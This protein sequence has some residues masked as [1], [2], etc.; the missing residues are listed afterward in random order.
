M[1]AKILSTI[2]FLVVLVLVSH[3]AWIVG[4]VSHRVEQ[5]ADGQTMASPPSCY[6]FPLLE[7]FA[8]AHEHVNASLGWA[9]SGVWSDEGVILAEWAF[10]RLVHI[11]ISYGEELVVRPIAEEGI[12]RHVNS[13]SNS[14]RN[15]G[16]PYFIHRRERTGYLLLVRSSYEAFRSVFLLNKERE[17]EQ[18]ILTR[19]HQLTDLTTGD[20]VVLRDVF[21]LVPI[22]SGLLLYGTVEASFSEQWFGYIDPSE[23][24][25]R[26]FWRATAEHHEYYGMPDHHYMAAT[27]DAAFFLLATEW[28]RIARVDLPSLEMR[29]LDHF[30]LDFKVP[31]VDPGSDRDRQVDILYD[32]YEVYLAARMAVGLIAW[33][34][35]VFIVGKGAAEISG[36]DSGN[37]W[38][39]IRISP[40]TGEEV[41]RILLPTKAPHIVLVPGPKFLTIIE[42][43]RIDMVGDYRNATL[44]R[45]TLSGVLLPRADWLDREVTAGA[46][47]CSDL[48]ITGAIY[49]Q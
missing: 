27:A 40:E 47:T 15:I 45:S 34:E 11:P 39:L 3:V 31:K 48:K 1:K 16:D 46:V 5:V 19:D 9:N 44:G 22:G 21:Q 41:S 26:R 38:W 33:D 12:L 37:D 43:G 25:Y 18:E 36:N 7:Y 14:F 35:K 24:T 8:L 2:A 23:S 32:K 13:D 4:S 17:I 10:Q 29:I 42:K 28:P 49:R 30:P 20:I 6:R